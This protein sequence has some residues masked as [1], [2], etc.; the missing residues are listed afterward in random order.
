MCAKLEEMKI[1][2][3]AKN[4]HDGR[5]QVDQS[6]SSYGSPLHL[7]SNLPMFLFLYDTNN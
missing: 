7:P 6:S 4:W 3:T 1:K 2:G 5:I